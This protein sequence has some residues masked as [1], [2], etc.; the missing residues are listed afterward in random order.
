[1]G[2]APAPATSLRQALPEAAFWTAK[3]LARHMQLNPK[4][5]KRLAARLKVPPTVEAHASHRWSA[6]AAATLLHRWA[7]RRDAD[8]RKPHRYPE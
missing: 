3:D 7:K 6:Q 2:S 1:M 8:E 4:T 5:V